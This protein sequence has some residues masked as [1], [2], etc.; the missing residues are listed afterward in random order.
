MTKREEWDYLLEKMFENA[1]EEHKEAKKEQI[2][3]NKSVIDNL[4]EYYISDD[5]KEAV[6]NCLFEMAMFEDRKAEFAY[7][8][9]V[10]D[11]AFIL[12]ELLI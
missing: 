1:L 2:R 7:R 12:K 8:R 11:C 3:Q 6:E 9:G 5:E 10:K 4:L